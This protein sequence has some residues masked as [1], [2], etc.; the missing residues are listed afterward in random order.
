MCKETRHSYPFIPVLA[1]LGT[2]FMGALGFK[3]GPQFFFLSAAILIT[4]CLCDPV[5]GGYMA[6][7]NGVTFWKWWKDSTHFDYSQIYS[8][9]VGMY[10]TNC[11]S[12]FV[13]FCY[14]TELETDN[15]FS[16]L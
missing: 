7:D 5:K 4:A 10:R 14:T 12:S 8:V 9:K 15:V 13:D 16:L 6:A 11:R 3:F 1:F 2:I